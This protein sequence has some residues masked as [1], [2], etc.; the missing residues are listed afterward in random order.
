MTDRLYNNLPR[1]GRHQGQRAD[2]EPTTSVRAQPAPRP[3]PP[4]NTVSSPRAYRLDRHKEEGHYRVHSWSSEAMEPPPAPEYEEVDRFDRFPALTQHVSA[5]DEPPRF[6]VLENSETGEV[7][8]D[9]ERDLSD[10]WAEEGAFDQ[11]TVFTDE[12]A[13]AAYADRRRQERQRSS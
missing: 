13:A 6:I 7:Y 10:N 2:E 11:A 12:P 3:E 9:H 4:T 5:M 8:Y 1:Q